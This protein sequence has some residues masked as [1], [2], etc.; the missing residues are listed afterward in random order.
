MCWRTAASISY[1]TMRRWWS[2]E[3]RSLDAAHRETTRLEIPLGVPL[4]E[5]IASLHFETSRDGA[6]DGSDPAGGDRLL[7][8]IAGFRAATGRLSHDSGA[9]FLSGSK[10]VCGGND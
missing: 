9:D 7:Y 10:S 4:L 3:R 1:R 2:R 5:S 8:A 6:A